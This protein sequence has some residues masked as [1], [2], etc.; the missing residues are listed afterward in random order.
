M[1]YTETYPAPAVPRI[2]PDDQLACTPGTEYGS[3][4]ELYE[5][6]Y[7]GSTEEILRLVETLKRLGVPL[8]VMTANPGSPLARHADLHLP[9][10][11]DREAC[12]LNLAPTASTTATRSSRPP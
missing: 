2:D 9:V 10:A 11:I 12:P 8:V 5:I 3:R 6:H 7:S 4:H 1:G